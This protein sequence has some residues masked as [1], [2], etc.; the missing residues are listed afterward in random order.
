MTSSEATDL[1]AGARGASQ[2]EARTAAPVAKRRGTP[3]REVMTT[4][5]RRKVAQETVK[6]K[7]RRPLFSQVAARA[8]TSEAPWTMVKGKSRNKKNRPE[9]EKEKERARGTSAPKPRK[10]RNRNDALLI[11]ADGANYGDVLRRMKSDA[12]LAG[13]GSDVKKIRRS[14]KGE[15]IVELKSSAKQG[16]QYRDL[17][18]Q[19]LGEGVEVRAL[20]TETTIQVKGLDEITEPAEVAE[21]LKEQCG[22]MADIHQIRL[23]KGPAGTQIALIR[24]IEAEARKAQEVTKLKVGWSVC[25]LSTYQPQEKCFKCLLNGHKAWQCRGPDRSKLCLRCG[26]ADHQVKT[27]TSQPKCLLC[28]Q[29]GVNGKHIMGSRKCAA[30]KLRGPNPQCR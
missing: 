13:L 17:A 15:L 16:S 29:K 7:D 14:R 23:H 20:R 6:G 1:N 22:L 11:K 9:K 30:S 19:V 8:A 2:R 12:K 10:R 5:K 28:T 25:P 26:G 24:L 21:A 3:P 27:C 18:E 4:S